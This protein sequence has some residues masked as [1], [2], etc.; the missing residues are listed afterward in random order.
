MTLT[1]HI[2]GGTIL[3]GGSGEQAHQY[4][5]RCGAYTYDL[6]APLPTGIDAVAN[7]AAYDAGDLESAAA[8]ARMGG[9]SVTFYP[10]HVAAE[11]MARRPDLRTDDGSTAI[12]A[13]L[14]WDTTLTADDAI[15]IIDASTA[16]TSAE[17][18]R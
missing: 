14:T 17:W 16:D 10:A 6:D 2:C 13:I 1:S 8:E 9:A 7:R 12:R 11:I 4:C 18:L 15:E 3:V 5:D